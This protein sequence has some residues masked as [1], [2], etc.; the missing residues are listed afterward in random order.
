MMPLRND[1]LKY[2]LEFLLLQPLLPARVRKAVTECHPE[3]DK[4]SD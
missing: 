4:G 1:I 2:R 3:L